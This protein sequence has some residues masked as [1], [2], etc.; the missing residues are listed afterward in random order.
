[1]ILHLTDKTT[2][3]L[4]DYLPLAE[5]SGIRRQDGLGIACLYADISDR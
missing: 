1:M 3:G 4:S 2:R 5:R